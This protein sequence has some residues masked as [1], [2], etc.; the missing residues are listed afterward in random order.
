MPACCKAKYQGE[1]AKPSG[2]ARAQHLDKVDGDEIVAC[3]RT[4][5]I[6]A[7]TKAWTSATTRRDDAKW[8]RA[9]GNI[10]YRSPIKESTRRLYSPRP[11]HARRTRRSAEVARHD[12]TVTG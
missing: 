3:D 4:G 7:D 1:R 10:E 9:C 2:L 5:G 8:T 6:M 12:C 11:S